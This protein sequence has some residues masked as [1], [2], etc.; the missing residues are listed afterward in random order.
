MLWMIIWWVTELIP[1]GF[2]NLLSPFIFIITGVRTIDETLPKFAYPIIWI[3]Y[4]GSF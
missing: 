3:L 1:L 2:T 4:S